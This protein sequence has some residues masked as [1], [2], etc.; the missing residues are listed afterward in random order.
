MHSLER[1]NAMKF[2]LTG[3]GLLIGVANLFPFIFMISSSFKPLSKIFEFPFKIIPDPFILKNY[4]DIMNP[5]YDFTRWYANSIVMV[6]LTLLFKTIIVSITAYSFARLRFR[7]KDKIFIIFLSALMLPGDVT[8]I[9]RYVIYKFINITDTVW[10]L[11]LPF[12]FDVYFVFLLRQF[13]ITIPNELTESAIIDGCGHLRIFYKIILPLAKPAVVTMLLFTFVWSWNDYTSPFIFIT[14][15]K[16][17][18]LT[19][20]IAMFQETKS[21]NYALQMAGSSLSLVPVLILF[22]FLQKYFVEG[23]ATSGIKG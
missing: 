19:V 11:V 3:F 2:F 17:Q 12:T 14:D 21:Q 4:I 10:A 20:G 18:M 15:V 6:V 22:L 13:F 9:Q 7:G 23:I 8:L 16:K 5:R 1:K